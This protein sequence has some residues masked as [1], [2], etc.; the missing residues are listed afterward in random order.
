MSRHR[1]CGVFAALWIVAVG[2]AW[3][4]TPA[5]PA[6]PDVAV[7]V[8]RITL[9]EFRRL[10]AADAVLT[11]DV[12]EAAAFRTGHVPKAINVPLAD[13][14]RRVPEIDARAG[15]RAIVVYCA[16]ADEHASALAV[17]RFIDRGMTHVSALIG[18]LRA[19]MAS[20]GRIETRD[21]RLL[22]R[23]LFDEEL[24]KRLG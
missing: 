9:D 4:Q 15:R 7:A 12:R 23:R 6:R 16:C 11:V 18:G 13:V 17:A 1:Q 14:E 8:P 22:Q 3:A 19:W 2:V 24:L 5:A 10:H 21:D 20:G